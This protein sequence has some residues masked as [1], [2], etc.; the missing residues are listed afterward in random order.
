MSDAFISCVALAQQPPEAELGSKALKE[1]LQAPTEGFAEAWVLTLCTNDW[2]KAILS[3]W[4]QMTF[5]YGAVM[6]AM[7]CWLQLGA[8]AL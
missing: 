5:Y 1:R 8:A 3:H 7:G 4:A 2:Q 6:T